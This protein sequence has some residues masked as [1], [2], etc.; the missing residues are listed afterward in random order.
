MKLYELTQALKQMESM[1]EEGEYTKEDLRD[2]LEALEMSIDEKVENIVKMV[3]NMESDVLAL[4]E[5]EKRL[6]GRRKALE[7]KVTGLKDYVSYTMTSVGKKEIKTPLFT[8]K[9]QKN[10]P[11]VD[12]YDEAMIP[13][14]FFKVDI[15]EK[16]DRKALLEHLKKGACIQ[17][18][19]LKQGESLRIK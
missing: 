2:T 5:E 1:I 17:G 14:E 13:G 11:S 15:V 10:P 4:K 3:R 12:V 19:T 7:S 9:F 8:A 18:A 6:E 16:L